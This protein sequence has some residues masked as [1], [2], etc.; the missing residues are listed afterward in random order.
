MSEVN[1]IEQARRG[2]QA[3]WSTLVTQHQEAVFRLTYLLLGDPDEANDAAQDAFIRAFQALDRFDSDR[4]LRPWLLSIAANQARNRRRAM[5]RY[6]A[7]LKRVFQS[8][9]PDLVTP[10]PGNQHQQQWEARTLW[11]AIRRLKTDDQEIIYLRYFLSLSVAETAEA[12]DI[13]PGTVKSR[14]SRALQRLQI[15]IDEQFPALREERVG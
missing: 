11:R 5:G 10:G 9:E 6:L 15:V 7:A 12:V 14:L 13:A 3:A 8:E 4:A 2:D 1:L